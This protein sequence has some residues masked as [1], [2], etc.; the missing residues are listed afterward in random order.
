MRSIATGSGKTPPPSSSTLP[1]IN[2]G[3]REGSGVLG[4]REG[5]LVRDELLLPVPPPRCATATVA[6][7]AMPIKIQALKQEELPVIASSIIYFSM[8]LERMGHTESI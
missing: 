6:T 4:V 2:T 7:V 8:A 1:E 5:T 3:C